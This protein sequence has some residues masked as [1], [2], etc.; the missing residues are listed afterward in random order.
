V[1]ARLRRRRL[2]SFKN[3]KQIPNRANC[4]RFGMTT[5]FTL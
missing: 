2:G 5:L 4:A 1:K 3:E